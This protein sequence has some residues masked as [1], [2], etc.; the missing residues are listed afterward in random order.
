MGVVLT[1]EIVHHNHRYLQIGEV[2]IRN[3]KTSILHCSRN[4]TWYYDS[5]I[6][7]MLTHKI[8]RLNTVAQIKWT[9]AKSLVIKYTFVK[10]M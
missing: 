9:L 8:R 5:V 6:K 10:L 2:Y 3:I 4:N 7:G 1:E